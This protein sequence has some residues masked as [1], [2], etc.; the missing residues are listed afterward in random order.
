[1]TNSEPGYSVDKKRIALLSISHFINDTYANYLPLLLPFLIPSLGLSLPMAGLLF[2]THQLT[3]SVIQPVLGHLADRFGTRVFSFVGTAAVAVGASSLGVAPSYGVLL[4]LVAL[5]GLGTASFHPQSAAMVNALSGGRRGTLMSLYITSGNAGF[6]LGPVIIVSVVE[7]LGLRAT[8][9]MVVPGIVSAIILARYAPR[10]WRLPTQRERPPI[11]R[12]IAN[13][14]GVLVSLLGV[15]T[16]RAVT[17]GGLVTFLPLFFQSKGYAATVGATLITILLISGTSG[18]LLGGYLSDRIGR[19]LVIAGSL[20][21]ATPLLLA[22]LHTSGVYLWIASALAGAAFLGSFSVLTV[23]TQEML[24]ENVGM[25]SGLML[26]FTVGM[27]GLSVGPLSLLAEVIG[28]PTTLNLVVLMPFLG[29]LVAL[30]LADQPRAGAK[31]PSG[32]GGQSGD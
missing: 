11:W 6:A 1:M 32:V 14:K 26:G 27:G 18:S 21:L 20:A 22:M 4:A 30:S 2:A 31:G 23:Q 10:G 15:A 12:V 16:F 25:A 24:P 3:S 8:P 13:K 17:Y 5:A 28:I 29:A 19:R 7:A 9:L